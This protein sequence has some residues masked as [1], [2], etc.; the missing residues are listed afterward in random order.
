MT[1]Q[2]SDSP[3]TTETSNLFTTNPK[4][5]IKQ[6]GNVLKTV[7]FERGSELRRTLRS[8]YD[9]KG[10]DMLV[11]VPNTID[12]MTYEHVLMLAGIEP[13]TYK[14]QVV[15]GS[16][17]KPEHLVE[18]DIRQGETQLIIELL[19]KDFKAAAI[20]LIDM[21]SD[22]G[23]IHVAYGK[24]QDLER[25]LESFGLK[26]NPRTVNKGMTYADVIAVVEK[27]KRVNLQNNS[28][29]N[30]VTK[31]DVKMDE[32]VPEKDAMS[33]EGITLLAAKPITGNES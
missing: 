6:N 29:S 14:I 25:Y 7:S 13:D 28:F 27:M 15:E 10:E 5:V 22:S 11:N 26:A 32:F 8:Y 18:D 2:N 1:T 20:T 31:K 12:Q 30:Y 17:V 21:N 23:E 16:V 3:L 4:I 33:I 19:N 24:G 9:A